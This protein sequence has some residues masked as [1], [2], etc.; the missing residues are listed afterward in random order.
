MFSVVIFLSDLSNLRQVKDLFTAGSPTTE[1][2]GD[3]SKSWRD[4]CRIQG[5]HYGQLRLLCQPREKEFRFI[6]DTDVRARVFASLTRLQLVL[7][8][9][10]Q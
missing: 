9:K 2:P 3:A 6:I 10:L 1:S 7:I 8:S 4:P 5:P